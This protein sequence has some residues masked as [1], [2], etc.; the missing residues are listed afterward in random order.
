MPLRKSTA[1]GGICF[2]AFP[3]EHSTRA[4][5]VG[6]R[7]SANRVQLFYVPDVV[8]IRNRRR[9]LRG[10]DLYLGDGAT[11]TRPI[12]RRRG[13]SMIGHTSI[14]TQLDWCK[15]D[16]VAIA[17]FTHCGSKIVAA[18][19]RQIRQIVGR[20]GAE[21]GVD[22]RIARD[23]LRLIL[24]DGKVRFAAAGGSFGENTREIFLDPVMRDG[25]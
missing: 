4:P 22:A 20:L 25:E 11:I 7:I 19:A 13:C 16:R 3:V 14:R 15:A 8:A 9:A 10:V 23:G 18:D 12:I 6:Y 1:I 2:E 21:R 24:E 5:A 17:Y